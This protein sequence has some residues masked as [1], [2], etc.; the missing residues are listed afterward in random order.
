MSISMARA[1]F[2]TV[3]RLQ[4]FKLD[5]PDVKV[6]LRWIPAP[7]WQATWVSADGVRFMVVDYTLAQLLDEVGIIL[8][9]YER[10]P[11]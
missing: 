4:R 6:D 9:P 11:P 10:L 8:D 3:V 7:H 1:G 5:H 2:D